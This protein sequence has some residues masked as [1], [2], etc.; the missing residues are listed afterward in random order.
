MTM[1]A[2]YPGGKNGSGVYQ[3][4]INLMPP[5]RVYVE[6]F[7]GN[8]AI[9]RL[10]RPAI[11]NIGIDS[12]DHVLALWRGNEVPRLTLRKADALE[13]LAADGFAPS[14]LIYCD[15]PYLMSTRSSQRPI[16]RHEFSDEA[17]HTELLTIIKRLNCMVMISGYYSDLYTRELAGWR[18]ATFQAQTRGGTTATEWVWMNFPEPLELHDYR[19]L[20]GNFRQRERIKRKQNRWRA[21]LLR[22]NSTERYSMLAT[23]EEL[24]TAP[25]LSTA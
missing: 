13:Y 3:A 6:P 18:T 10:K 21:R 8:G 4:I 7:L 5:H 9:M 14:T 2:S 23:L 1:P 16:Y 15:P 25:P 11:A 20:G 12:D 17:Q 24:R 19:Y 22:M